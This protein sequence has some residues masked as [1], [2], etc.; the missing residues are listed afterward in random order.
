[1]THFLVLYVSAAMLASSAL[2]TLGVAGLWALR[3]LRLEQG[4]IPAR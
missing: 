2:V 4:R 3:G 1:M